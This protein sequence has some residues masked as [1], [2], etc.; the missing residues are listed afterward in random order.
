MR[1]SDLVARLGGDEFVIL[2]QEVSSHADV[3]KVTD[4]ILSSVMEPVVLQGQECRVTASIGVAMCPVDGID[5]ETLTKNA[6]VAMYSAKE[7]GKNGAR[8]FAA[9]MKTQSIERLMMENG[10][11][12]ALDRNE[13]TL[14]YQPK[15]DILSNQ[16][17]GVEALLRWNYSDLGLV[18]P[19]I[20]PAGG[21]NRPHRAIGKWVLKTAC[22]QSVA[23][24]REGLN[25]CRWRSIC[26]R[27]SSTPTVC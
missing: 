26:R 6:D 2:L 19:M 8:F 17:T 7:E 13:F 4:K 25:H 5:A 14:H 22:K 3:T 12:Q 11:R 21:G 20:D 23:W 18:A 27:A 1:T 16:I 15:R 24:Q 10:L 9:E